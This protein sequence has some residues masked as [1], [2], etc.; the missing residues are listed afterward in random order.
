VG[1]VVPRDRGVVLVVD[2]D[3]DYRAMLRCI[4]ERERYFVLEARDGCDAL[5]VLHSGAAPAIRLIVLDL[6]MPTM[7]GWQLVDV[8]RH[9]PALSRVPVLVTS[10]IPVHGDASGIGATIPSLGKPIDAGRLLSA[11]SDALL[12]RADVT[13]TV[14]ANDAGV[15]KRN[16]KLT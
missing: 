15:P 7:T 12:R 6:A 5:D 16:T 3:E 9:D 14:P 2:D 11:V 4:L 10:A 8:L 13:A 1:I